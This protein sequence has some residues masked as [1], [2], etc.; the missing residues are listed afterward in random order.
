MFGQTKRPAKAISAGPKQVIDALPITPTGANA[1]ASVRRYDAARRALAEAKRID[2]V[3]SIRDQAVAIQVYAHQAKDRSLIED[4][5]EIRLRAERRAGE[6]LVEMAK[7]KG[8]AGGG[9]KD[10]PRGRVVRPRD[11]SPRLSDVGITKSQSS[12]W[13][14]LAG[15]DAE[16]FELRVVAARKEATNGLDNV[17]RAIKQQAAR[18]A[19]YESRIK[20]GCTIDDLCALAASGYKAAVIYVDVPS[21]FKPFSAEGKQRSAEKH[22]DTEDVAA[23]KAMAPVIQTLAAKDCALFYW[24]S[25]P[26]IGQALEII[27]TCRFTY[28]TW[29][30]VWVKTK[31]SS[32]ALDLDHLT[33]SDLRNGMGYTSRANTEVVLLAKHGSPTRLN[34][35]VQQVVIAPAAR[36]SEK[37]D[38]VRRRIERLYAGPYLELFGRQPVE[39]WT[40]WGNEIARPLDPLAEAAAD[41]DG[42]AN[43]LRWTAT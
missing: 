24:S 10:G 14:R 27:A 23:L 18:A 39:G 19:G 36:H 31:R 11:I 25:G 7:N 13:Q 16:A 32:G 4:A 17:H 37:P 21:R 6:L 15:L 29:A 12:K 41:G 2:D 1:K 9:I 28:S 8:A 22:Y 26:F 3:K 34:N 30:F 43:F 42:S 33:A 40:V 5:T 38:E 35:D 20:G